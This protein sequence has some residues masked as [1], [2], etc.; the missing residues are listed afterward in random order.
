MNIARNFKDVTV[1]PCNFVEL[2]IQNVKD[3]TQ[4][5]KFQVSSYHDL[6][7]LVSIVIGCKRKELLIKSQ[8]SKSIEL[9]F[10]RKQYNVVFE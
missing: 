10:G 6:F 9:L 1:S 5:Q 2:E 4:N 7:D 3:P 8:T